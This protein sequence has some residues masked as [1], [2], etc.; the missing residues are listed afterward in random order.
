P[1]EA[2]KII[3]ER[4]DA[5]NQLWRRLKRRSR[6]LIWKNRPIRRYPSLGRRRC[7]G[8]V[9][10]CLRPRRFAPSDEDRVDEWLTAD[11]S[12]QDRSARYTLPRCCRG[13]R[14]GRSAQASARGC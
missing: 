3:S 4:I 9:A 1:K 10:K 11:K 8:D 13:L 5:I 14:Q 7:G 6:S 12:R 2:E